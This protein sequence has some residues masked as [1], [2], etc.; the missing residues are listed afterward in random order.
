MG[1]KAVSKMTKHLVYQVYLGEQNHLYDTCVQSVQKYC[2]KYHLDHI[3]QR[4]PILKITPDLKASNR[5]L[6]SFQRLGY[7]PI[8]EKEN[9]FSYLDRYDSIAI[10]DADIYIKD[11]S[12]NIFDEIGSHDF[13]GVVER[14]MPITFKYTNKIKSYS[15]GQY[16]SLTD[17][18]WKWNEKGAEFMNMGMMLLNKS[19]LKY[20]RGETPYEFIR[21]PEFKRFVDGLGSWKWSTDQ[22]LLNYWIKKEKMNVKNLSWKW[23]ALYTAIDDQLLKESYFIHF[24]LRDH[25]PN[26]G[27]DIESHIRTLL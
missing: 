10:V 19:I 9:A 8:Y 27:N 18:D 1:S 17:V 3:I 22:T 20:L 2:D 26:K 5:S 7:L 11:A 4:E 21:R 23:N 25:L 12:P 6:Q 16:S 14:E 13:A 15:K 24:F